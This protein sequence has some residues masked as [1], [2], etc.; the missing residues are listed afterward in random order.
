MKRS[1]MSRSKGVSL[2]AGAVLA[3]CVGLSLTP[4]GCGSNDFL[5]LEDYQRD[6]LVWLLHHGED[7]SELACWD[8]NGNGVEDLDEEDQNRDG[9]VNDFDCQGLRCWDLLTTLSGTICA[10]S[11]RTHG[12]TYCTAEENA[13]AS[14]S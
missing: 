10:L 8:V 13:T 11:C 2:V 7:A 6:I 4:A 3:L 12:R 1:E 9:V 5:G 14:R